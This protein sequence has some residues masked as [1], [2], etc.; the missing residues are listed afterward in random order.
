MHKEPQTLDKD[1]FAQFQKRQ[2]YKQ[3]DMGFA[4]ESPKTYACVNRVK[5]IRFDSKANVFYKIYEE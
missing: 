3:R 2:L 1:K 4:V 5:E